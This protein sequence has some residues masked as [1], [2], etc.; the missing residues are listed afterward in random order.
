ML[1]QLSPIPNILGGIM[2]GF[3]A[4]LGVRVT[5]PMASLILDMFDDG[6]MK[7]VAVLV[8]W[9]VYVFVLWVFVWI[10]FFEPKET[11]GGMQ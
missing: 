5:Y 8:M 3:L 10:K 7:V 11:Q 9:L 2:I 1:K 4:I 6:I